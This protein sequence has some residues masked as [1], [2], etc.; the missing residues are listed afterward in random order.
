MLVG[1]SRVGG[2]RGGEVFWVAEKLCEARVVAQAVEARVNADEGEAD[3][4]FARGAREPCESL[5]AVAEQGV[6][7]RRLV[8][9]DAFAVAAGEQLFEDWARAVGASGGGER[10]CELGA[11]GRRVAGEGALFFVDGEGFVEES[12]LLVAPAQDDV[13]AT[14]PGANSRALGHC[15]VALSKGR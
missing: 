15:S 5:F 12:A 2:A 11:H 7:D 9:R 3:G 8:G 6:D 14:G 13:G 10:V 4:A 1:R